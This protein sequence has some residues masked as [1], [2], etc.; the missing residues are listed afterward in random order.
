MRLL[1]V[2]REWFRSSIKFR[3]L[4][5]TGVIVSVLM[6]VISIGILLQWRNLIIEQQKENALSVSRAFSIPVIETLIQSEREGVIGGDLL[7]SHIQNFLDNVESITYI[8]IQDNEHRIIAHSDLSQ[9]DQTITDSRLLSVIESREPV[10]SV[11]KDE[12]HGWTLEA[13]QPLQIGEKR[14]G[15]AILGFEAQTTRDR[16]SRSFFQLLFLTAVALTVTLSLIYY[17]INRVMAS[18]RNLVVEVDKID[19]GSNEPLATNP[20]NDEIGFLLKHFEMLKK[21]LNHSRQE[22]AMAQHQIYQAEKL[23]SI[24]RL[25]SGV[26][27]EVNNPLNGMRFCVYGIQ[28]DM[29]NKEQTQEYLKLIN[30]GL[31]QIESVVTKL[32]GYSRQRPKSSE[33]VHIEK[34]VKMVLDLL[35][36]RLT[37]KAIRVTIEKDDQFPEI[38]ADPNLIQEMLMNLLLNSLDAV[39]KEGFI[40]VSLKIP[41]ENH[42]EIRIRDN[43]TGIAEEEREVIF[44]PFYTTKETGRGTGLGLSVTHGIVQSHNGT[45]KVDSK[46]GEFTEFI[47]T[48]PVE[49]A[50]EDID[51]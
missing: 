26:A 5:V 38:K 1:Q 24:G 35:E 19:L 15:S 8:S 46:I 47:I 2:L 48:I 42:I 6:I 30:E 18:L 51:R 45:I 11:F 14:W 28:K 20:G 17:F 34:K 21:R 16:I 36:Y 13:L 10:T 44:E 32:L 33:P 12:V 27:H 50:H 31:V 22:L 7:E 39:D 23:A 29:D 4:A 37:E 43:G 3:I 41:D 40:L 49:S 25:A 9:Y